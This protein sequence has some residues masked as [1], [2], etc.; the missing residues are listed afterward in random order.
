MAAVTVVLD[1]VGEG[2]D[3]SV[4]TRWGWARFA[5]AVR[6]QLGATRWYSRIVRAVFDAATDPALAEV[7]VRPQRAGALERVGDALADLAARRTEITAVDARMVGVLDQLDLTELEKVKVTVVHAAVGAITEGDV[8]L[9]LAARAI[10]IGFNVRPAGKASSLAQKEGVQ[11]RHYTVIYDTVNDV[12]K[13]MEGM[14]EPTRVEKHLGR[15]EIRQL[16]KI[17]KAG[18]VAGCMVT[19]GLIR[20]AAYGRLLRQNVV[21][22]DGNIASLKRFKEDVREVKEGFDCGI[23]FD[24]FT[25]IKEGDTLE[26]YDIEEVRQ[27]SDPN[28]S[29]RRA[30]HGSLRA[31]LGAIIFVG[32][33]RFVFQIPALAPSRIGGAWS[34]ASRTACGR[35]CR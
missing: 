25:D 6:A 7:G 22:W 27:T 35:S 9:A 29:Q 17:S 31:P 13:A 30:R 12:K 28:R 16:F 11:I 19:E 4:I 34:K 23:S 10:I 5:A 2:G 32:V 18:W 3:L 14:L 26:A 33:A 20:R 21:V 15:A 1:R 8:N 24:N